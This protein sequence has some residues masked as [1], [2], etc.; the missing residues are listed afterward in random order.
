MI[1]FINFNITYKNVLWIQLAVLLTK[2]ITFKKE[3]N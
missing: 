3:E 1:S 2:F